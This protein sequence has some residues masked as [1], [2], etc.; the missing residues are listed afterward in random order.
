MSNVNNQIQ[1]QKKTKVDGNGTRYLS[2]S[3]GNE[4]YAIPLLS[5]KE[6]I[7]VPD[8]TPV[9]FTPSYF[10]GIMNLR[11]QIIS[12]IDLRQKMGIKAKGSSETSVIICDLAPLTLGVVVDSIDSVLSPREEDISERPEVHGA[13]NLDFITGVCKREEGLVVLIDIARMLNADDHKS[14]GAGA[15][16]KPK[17]A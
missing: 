2:F 11:G 14:I 15:A 8:T 1:T 3:L 16:A 4:K 17:A 12:V 5:V 13:K 6:V 9:P 10:L 7:A